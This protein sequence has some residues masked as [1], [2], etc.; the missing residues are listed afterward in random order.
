MLW[1]ESLDVIMALED[2]VLVRLLSGRVWSGRYGR[3]G[4]VYGEGG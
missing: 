1:V 3:Y 2:A 4:L